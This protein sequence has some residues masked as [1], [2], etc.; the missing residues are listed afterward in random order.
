MADSLFCA[1]VIAGI[2]TAIETAISAIRVPAA[3]N[4]IIL[5]S[6]STSRSCFFSISSVHSLTPFKG[7]LHETEKSCT[8]EIC[9]PQEGVQLEYTLA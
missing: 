9:G 8:K 3:N 4:R 2:D 6:Y 7:S 5:P 1:N